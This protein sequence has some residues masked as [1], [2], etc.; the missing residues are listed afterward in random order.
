VNWVPPAAGTIAW[1]DLG[2]GDTTEFAA[3]LAREQS[4]LVVPG[5]LFDAPGHVRVALGTEAGVLEEA[6]RR[7]GGALSVA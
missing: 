7:M 6:L 3:R 2:I 1:L 5:Y 4:T